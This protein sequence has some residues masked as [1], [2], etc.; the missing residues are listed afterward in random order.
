M[1]NFKRIFILLLL[2]A[3]V[4]LAIFLFMERE[5]VSLHKADQF[6]QEKNALNRLLANASQLQRDWIDGEDSREWHLVK[7][8]C[9][10]NFNI[11]KKFDES[12]LRC[13]PM[14]IDCFSQFSKNKNYSFVKYDE[15][16]GSPYR[17]LTHSITAYRDLK[18]F[19]YSVKIED[20]ETKKQLE[21]LLESN[22]QEVYLEQRTY[23]YGEQIVERGAVDYKF[24]TY[25]RHIYLDRTLV[26]NWD[27]NQWIKFGSK[28][29]TVG[30]FPRKGNELFLPATDLNLVQMKNYC[31]YQ[32][33]QLLLAHIFDAATFLPMDLKDKNP[34]ILHRSPYYW[35]KKSKDYR[36][37]C[38][39]IYT[40]E[41]LSEREFTLNSTSP[42]WAG[43]YE[44]QGGVFE[45]FDNP[46]DPDSNLKASSYYFEK[47]SSWHRLGFRA[48]WDGEGHSYKNFNFRGL[49]PFTADEHL[50]VAFRCMREVGQ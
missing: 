40:K 26:T 8:Q 43:I 48:G 12:L 27:I 5:E 23:G 50:P 15:V 28:E 45:V 14:L 21:F 20:Q 29:M 18:E 10:A 35:T 4:L 41:C 38:S 42:T 6:V 44:A 3:G 16:G 46:I 9:L 31:S 30:L 24:D 22:C 11:D 47:T 17:F 7:N 1:K 39:L 36:P 33:K 37:N 49:S 34:R 13:N 19:G 2:F 32:G 25:N